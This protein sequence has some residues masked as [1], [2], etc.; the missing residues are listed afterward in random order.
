M[1]RQQDGDDKCYQRVYVHREL[2][3]GETYAGQE[4]EKAIDARDFIEE[5]GERDEFGSCPQGHKV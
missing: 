5:K 1:R 3:K 2:K 4:G